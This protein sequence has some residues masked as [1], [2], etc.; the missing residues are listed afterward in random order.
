MHFKIV[1]DSRSTDI[2]ICGFVVLG[3]AG[4]A[5]L[6]VTGGAVWPGASELAL[7]GVIT[8][9]GIIAYSAIT[10]AMRVG[11]IS[12]VSP[13]RYSRLPFGIALGVLV[14]A[15]RPDA[16]TLFGSVIILATGIYILLRTG[17]SEPA[18]SGGFDA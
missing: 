3:P 9:V 13:F 1:V 5:M 17:R 6:L 2:G 14:F 8:V 10:A 18:T 11:S 16:L 15:E 4:A 7:I 12:V